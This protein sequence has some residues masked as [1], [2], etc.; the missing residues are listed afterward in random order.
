[1]V[2]FNGIELCDIAPARVVDIAVGSPEVQ[3][4][5]QSQPLLD[6]TRFIRRVR[7]ARPVA[8]SFVLMEEDPLLRRRLL[9]DITAWLSAAEPRPLRHTPEEDGFLMAVCTQY[10]D[11]SS[12]QYWE[13][14]TLA[15]TAFDPAY[16]GCSPMIQPV[17]APAMVIHG[18][19][20]R[21][22]ITQDIA[23]PLTDP[24]WT[25]GTAFL[26]LRGTVGVGRLIIDF[27]R[28]TIEL[29]GQSILDQLTIDSA[30]FALSRGAN[31][32]TVEGGA[33][34]TLTWRERWI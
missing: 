33:G 14:L 6:G 34:G 2:E 32:I 19:P 17:T 18:E 26:H 29:S 30:F 5:S 7:G 24:R 25:L 31:R 3:V 23:A 16:T 8:V 11:Q 1:M 20:P 4:T 22:T 28:Q 12:R 15:F 10:P 13:V 27:H 9:E 21:M